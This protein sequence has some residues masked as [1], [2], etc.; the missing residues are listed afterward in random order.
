MRPVASEAE[1]RGSSVRLPVLSAT[2]TGTTTLSAFHRALMAC[3]VGHFNLVRLSSV[4]PPGV[5][6]GP[7]DGDAI[8]GGW[9]DRLY[10]VYA[11]M[12]VSA[13]GEQAWAGVGWIQRLDGCGGLLVEHEAGDEGE[14]VDLV[15][16]S[17]ADM[18]ADE[19]HAFSAPEWVVA[20]ARCDELPTA[21]LVMVPFVTAL[22]EL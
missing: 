11:D 17:L 9:G 12:R 3:G 2:A 20:G 19:P 22:W 21:A 1:L 6:V 10:C 15:R 7:T 4:I 14:V 13:P 5:T 16:R 8:A 18:A